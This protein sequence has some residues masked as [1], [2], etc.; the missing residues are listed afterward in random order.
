[1]NLH[2]KTRPQPPPAIPANP[3]KTPRKISVKETP[4]FIIEAITAQK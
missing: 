3:T 1:M 4:L 2:L